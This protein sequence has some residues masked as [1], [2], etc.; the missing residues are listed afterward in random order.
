MME[1]FDKS[2]FDEGGAVAPGPDMVDKRP[3]YT[4][5]MRWLLLFCAVIG[6]VF[7]FVLFSDENLLHGGDKINIM[8][9]YGLFWLAYLAAFYYACW[10]RAGK[11]L[12]AWLIALSSIWFVIRPFVYKEHTLYIINF[13]ALPL[14]LMLH[15][16]IVSFDIPQEREL[17]GLLAWVKGWFIAP[18]VRI[19]RFFGCIGSLA[20]AGGDAKR[21]SSVRIGLLI[22]L[23]MVVVAALLLINA[24]AALRFYVKDSLNSAE[25]VIARAITAFIIAMLFYSFIFYMAYDKPKIESRPYS[26]IIPSAAAVTALMML[27]VLY[28]VFAAFQFTYLTGLKGLP[29]GMTYSEYAVHG[30]NELCTV[31]C[32]NIA[33]FI[34]LNTFSAKSK[35]LAACLCALMVCTVALV[36]CAGFRLYM[37]IEA[38]GLTVR[39]I[40]S[41]WFMAALLVF[42]VI[43]IVKLYAPSLRL[44]RTMAVAFVALYMLLNLL[45]IDAI[46][47]KTVLGRADATGYMSEEDALYLKYELSSDAAPV[48]EQSERWRER[49]QNA[50]SVPDGKHE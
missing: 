19:G 5:A 49:I 41:L 33:V 13:I 20:R 46:I 6:M 43:C 16:V 38:Y 2:Y 42:A 30:F 17:Y 36:F 32:L 22:G 39:R 21:A 29:E 35:G 37:Y 11:N 4:A 34:I 26:R 23:P 12:P 40:L 45:N 1:R 9:C 31:G 24:D 15:A 7:A 44:L 18:F 14:M 3:G 48:I 25:S 8:L 10:H 28:A 47:A 50:Y 27:L